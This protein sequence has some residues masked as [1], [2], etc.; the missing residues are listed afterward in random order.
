MDNLDLNEKISKIF[1]NIEDSSLG[2]ESEEDI[3]G[4]FDDLDLRSSRLGGGVIEKNEKIRNLL[5]SV[6]DFKFDNYNENKID[7]FGDAYEFLMRMYASSA[8]KSGGEF[9]TPQEV[10]E[11]MAKIALIDKKDTI[12]VYDPACGSGSLLL[13]YS[14]IFDNEGKTIEYFGQES[15]HTTYNLCRINMFLH[16]VSFNNFDIKYGDSLLCPKHRDEKFDA[17]VSNPPYSYGKGIKPNGWR[18]DKSESILLQDE[19]FVSASDLAPKKY[20]DWAFSLHILHH[21]KSSGIA[22]ILKNPTALSRGG[23]E[24]KIREYFIRENLIDTIIQLPKNLFFTVDIDVS[25]MVLKK[26]YRDNS[27]LFID[28]KNEFIKNLGRAN[29]G[30]DKNILSKHNIQNILDLVRNRKNILDKATLVENRKIIENGCVLTP[31]IYVTKKATKKK[32]NIIKLNKEIKDIVSRQ[33]IL[34]KEIDAIVADLES[35][36][37]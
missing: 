23:K 13:K 27:V 8:G 16:G 34:R 4:L 21:L 5:Q 26:N 6:D 20:A 12:K 17:I 31:S 11:L 1:K 37:V 9:F 10:S 2:E 19:R 22:V 7:V 15:N 32:T 14:K 30:K 3:K 36:N 29:K 24:Q 35:A 28:A 25:L 18:K 33:E